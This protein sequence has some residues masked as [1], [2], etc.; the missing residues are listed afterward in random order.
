MKR[1]ILSLLLGTLLLGC[2]SSDNE[3]VDSASA[4]QMEEPPAMPETA[5]PEPPPPPIAAVESGAAWLERVRTLS[6]EE[7]FE[8]IVRDIRYAPYPG[9]FRGPEGTARTGSSNALDQAMLL[10]EGVGG[11]VAAYRFAQGRL[12]DEPLATLLASMHRADAPRPS[13]SPD[14]Y[15]LYDPTQDATLADIARD[16]VWLE[17]KQADSL[18][19]VPLDPSYPGAGWG[20]AFAEAQRTFETPPDAM[21][22]TLTIEFMQETEDG[23]T[24]RLGQLRGAVAEMAQEPI[25]LV[26]RGIPQREQ[27]QVADA[28][29]SGGP[30]GG[31]GGLGRSLGDGLRVGEQ[32]DEEPEETETDEPPE[33]G[34]LV[35]TEYRRE[36]WHGETPEVLAATM[37]RDDDPASH[38]KREW[39]EF[40]LRVPGQPARTLERTLYDARSAAAGSPPG[41]R[42]YTITLLPGPVSEASYAAQRQDALSQLEAWNVLLEDF[43]QMPETNET[44]LESIRLEATA[45]G[46]V[47]HLINLAF[48]AASDALTEDLATANGIT[49]IHA[50]PRI[51]ISSVETRREADGNVQSDVS[52]DLR[53]DAVQAVPY[54]GMPVLA[55]EMF[56]RARGMQESALE[57]RVLARFVED[58]EQIVTTAALMHEAQEQGQNLVLVSPDNRA[59]L[60]EVTGLPES[61]AERINRALDAGDE[62]IVPETAVAIAGAKRWGWWQV[63]AE[64]GAFT[65]VLEGGQHQAMASYTITLER[66]GLNDDMG[67]A[68]GLIAGSNATLMLLAAKMLEHG[69]ITEAVKQEVAA[70]IEYITCAICPSFEVKVSL[71]VD[72]SIG[73]DCYK[74]GIGTGLEAGVGGSLAFCEKYKKG[75]SCAASLILNGL[76]V[77][78]E[79][80]VS[81]GFD[82]SITPLDCKR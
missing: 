40:D 38:I 47:G 56:Q 78:A 45:G 18:D 64:T 12:D 71:G 65:G 15:D 69:Q 73:N 60:D 17:V 8:T 35:G 6:P 70:L 11:Q 58:P 13:F 43:R 67:F 9:I 2:G 26:V 75:I 62:I 63:D 61:E 10:A 30:L 34:P 23:R 4:D 1:L 68:L 14:E 21:M 42:R 28:E 22:Q 37:V 27:Q 51:L 46:P 53:L 72:A 7:A 16:H 74:A 39:I 80:G 20:E 36:V 48:A 24:E 81:G 33:P 59:A 77:K 44:A 49:V 32:Q 50:L 5:V 25:A 41:Y 52:L 79:G 54:T 19:W 31:L 3:N 55:A 82:S 66:V 76:E 29:P 57:G